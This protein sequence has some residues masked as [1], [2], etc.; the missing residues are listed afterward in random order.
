M[1]EHTPYSYRQNSST[2]EI[3]LVKQ[4]VLKISRK[5]ILDI[6]KLSPHETET[7]VLNPLQLIKLTILSFM[8]SILRLKILLCSNVSLWA[9]AVCMPTALCP[10]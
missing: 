8:F 9:G 10:K 2:K 1:S 5:D 6:F 3:R 4:R 7:S